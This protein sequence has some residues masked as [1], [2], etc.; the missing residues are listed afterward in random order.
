M[1][2]QPQNVCFCSPGFRGANC[3][4]PETT[5]ASD[6]CLNGGVCVEDN[7]GVSCDCAAGWEGDSCQIN[8]DDCTP[9]PCANDGVCADGINSF[10]CTC[11][12]GFTGASCSEPILA[13]CKEIL[14]QNGAA[15]S[16]TYLV[17]PDGI[18]VGEPP[19]E[20]ACDMLEDGG[21][22]TLVGRELPGQTGTF[23]FLSLNVGDTTA[24]SLG[25]NNDLVG[26]A[27]F[28]GCIAMSG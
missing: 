2:A 7:G 12:N 27:F 25:E 16:G 28:S 17:D 9:N 24:A 4:L 21:G 6:R 20:T 11:S 5:C 19:F 3:E 26:G 15:P 8:H 1:I 13:T 22:W 10:S 23:K 14:A 18:D